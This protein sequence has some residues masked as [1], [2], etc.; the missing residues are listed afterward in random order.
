MSDANVKFGYRCLL[1]GT[2]IGV[3]VQMG[4]E[5]SACPTCGGPMV[6]ATGPTAPESLANYVCPNCHSA[7]GLV[8]SLEPITACPQCGHPIN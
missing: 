3:W 6:P 4:Q 8:V 1:C 2:T 5:G 7:F